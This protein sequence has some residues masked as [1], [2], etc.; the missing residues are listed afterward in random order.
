[1]CETQAAAAPWTWS[2]PRSGLGD[3]A[4]RGKGSL[5]GRFA[6]ACHGAGNREG[7]SQEEVKGADM[8]PGSSAMAASAG[9]HGKAGGTGAMARRKLLRAAVRK[10]GTGSS[11]GGAA[12]GRGA[13]LASSLEEGARRRGRRD[14][15]VPAGME[16]G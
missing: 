15:G 12:T 11:Q 5:L 7:R 14:L 2:T 9:R 4:R 10:T 16:L 3:P 8:L 1:M 13:R 6:G